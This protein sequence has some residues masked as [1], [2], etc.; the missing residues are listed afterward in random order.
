[1]TV[2]H[3]GLVA[4][5]KTFISIEDNTIVASRVLNSQLLALELPLST[6]AVEISRLARINDDMWVLLCSKD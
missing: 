5:T 2:H 3:Q 6:T 4:T 1:M